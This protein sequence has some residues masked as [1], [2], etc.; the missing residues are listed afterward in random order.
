AVVPDKPA[1]PILEFS[2]NGIAQ[3]YTEGSNVNPIREMTKMIELTRTFESIS[4]MIDSG[5]E[6]QQRA[7]EELGETS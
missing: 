3:G 5:S 4:K 2:E 6:N 7:I 1:N